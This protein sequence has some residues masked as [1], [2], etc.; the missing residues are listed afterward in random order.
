MSVQTITDIKRLT[1]P[2]TSVPFFINETGGIS[3]SGSAACQALRDAGKV[4]HSLVIS[5]NELTQTQ[6]LTFADFAT[7]SA[8]DTALGIDLD[9]QFIAHGLANNYVY[10]AQ[11]NPFENTGIASPFTCTTVYTFPEG[12][13]TI[14]IFGNALAVEPKVQSVTVGTNT[15]TVV[16]QFANSADYT[17]NFFADNKFVQQLHSKGVT[18]TI[19]FAL[20]S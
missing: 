7:Y 14:E 2:S 1:R 17:A 16:N 18:R 3:H 13:A 9:N 4:T 15:V 11:I 20:V 5:D 12:E 19:T 8:Y 6:T 10:E